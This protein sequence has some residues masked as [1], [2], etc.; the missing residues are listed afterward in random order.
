SA[1]QPRYHLEMTLLRWIHLRKLM[2]IEELIQSAGAGGALPRQVPAAP[3]R[4]GPATPSTPSRPVSNTALPPKPQKVS[5]APVSAPLSGV[6]RAPPAAP[7][8]ATDGPLKDAFL[9]EV[10]KTTAMAYNTVVVQAQRIEVRGDRIV[11]AYTA[12]QKIGP[13]FERYQSTL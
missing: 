7:L 2:P 12:A 1:A 5:S 8:V 13:A 9:T 4:S 6:P 3:T 10:R 11:L